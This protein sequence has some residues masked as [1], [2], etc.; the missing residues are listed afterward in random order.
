MVDD[1]GAGASERQ[2]FA[3]QQGYDGAYESEQTGE[4]EQTARC[5]ARC[6]EGGVESGDAKQHPDEKDDGKIRDQKEAGTTELDQCGNP[7]RPG[8]N[9]T[10][11]PRWVHG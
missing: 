10:E 5:E 9:A 7:R 4:D 1:V 2:P 3:E 8:R 11:L 6:C